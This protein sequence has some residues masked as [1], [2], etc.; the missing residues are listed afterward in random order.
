MQHDDGV[1]DGLWRTCVRRQK[2]ELEALKD[3]AHS[4]LGFK[5]HKVLSD[6]GRS[7][8]SIRKG[9]TPAGPWM[10]FEKYSQKS[11]TKGALNHQSQEAPLRCRSFHH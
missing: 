1:H 8:A 2:L 11:S 6:V 7:S 4:H 9:R 5:Q 3:H 10:P